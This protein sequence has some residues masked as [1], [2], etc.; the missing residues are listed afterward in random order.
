M[1]FF[2]YHLY[3]DY[4][5]EW[6]TFCVCQER[7]YTKHKTP[8]IDWLKFIL[9]FGYKD[10]RP[11]KTQT[12]K[13]A[14]ILHSHT[15]LEMNWCTCGKYRQ[16][17]SILQPSYQIPKSTKIIYNGLVI[18]YFLVLAGNFK[19]EKNNDILSCKFNTDSF[20]IGIYYNICML[21]S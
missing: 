5:Y 17:N 19:V 12:F 15:V 8:Q 18:K 16:L 13:Y 14:S 7:N 2:S 10:G 1:L 3:S 20:V 4:F 11:L 6:V 9:V 21:I